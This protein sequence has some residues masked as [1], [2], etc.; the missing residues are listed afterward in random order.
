MQGKVDKCQHRLDQLKDL[1]QPVLN[2]SSKGKLSKEGIQEPLF[3]EHPDAC[4]CAICLDPALH[5]ITINHLTSLSNYFASVSRPEQSIQALEVAESV[6]ESAENKTTRTLGRINVVLCGAKPS[7]VRSKATKKKRGASS[8]KGRKPKEETT[9]TNSSISQLMFSR[10]CITLYCMNAKLLLQNGKVEKA[11]AVLS[12]AMELLC[13]AQDTNGNSLPVCLL[14]I[15]ASLLHLFA[16]ATLSSN[17]GTSSDASVDCN[18]FSKKQ[19]RRISSGNTEEVTNSAQVD[20][21]EEVEL[22]MPRKGSSRRCRTS[23]NVGDK[24][25]KKSSRAK[26]R[27]KSK[28]VEEILVE[29]DESDAVVPQKPKGRSKRPRSARASCNDVDNHIQGI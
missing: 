4:E 18:W 15:K 20:A 29:D 6:C 16:V 13:R 11:S 14:P 23:K 12:G 8:A 7:D 5:T 3:I 25:E 24:E 10:H 2:S 27:G 28:K 22:E 17:E 26:G 1:L 9:V 21:V 19:T